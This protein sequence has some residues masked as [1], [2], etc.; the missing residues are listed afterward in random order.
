VTG[1]RGD[2]VLNHVLGLH[3]MQQELVD[4]S[5]MELKG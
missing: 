2:I 3:I 1:T 5:R 4:K